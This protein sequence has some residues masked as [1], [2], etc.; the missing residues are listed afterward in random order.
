[1]TVKITRRAAV[2]ALP[3][4][5]LAAKGI[6]YAQAQSKVVKVGVI[7]PMSGPLS[8]YAQE[9][10][11]VI[12]YLFDKINAEG[13]IKSMGG[14]KVELVVADDS[15]QPARAAIEARRLATQENVSVIMGTLLS[16]QMLG[17][18]PIVDEYKVPTLALWAGGA[19]ANH[20]YSLGFPYDRGYAKS[21]ADF[22]HDTGK[23]KTAVVACSDFSAGQKVSAFL[24]EMLKNHGIEVV[25]DVPLDTKATDHTAAMLRIRSMKPDAVIGLMQPRNGI[26][27]MQ[28]R[29][30][31]NYY[32]GA[33]IGNSPY[34]DTVIWR[35]LG[36]QIGKAVL[37]KK[38]F[39]MASF[40]E[41]AKIDSTRTL[42]GELKEKAKL[43]S[44]IGQA[45][46]Q[47]AQGVR[48]I[49]QALE[50][51]GSTDRE[52]IFKA[53]AKVNIPFG[54]KYLYLSRP[55]GLTFG[56]DRMPNDSTAMMVQWT[57]EAKH[58]VVWPDQYAQTKPAL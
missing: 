11:P 33:F 2:A 3:G 28:A 45:A 49:Q 41:G 19:K 30:N 8:S 55:K 18:S 36:A 12:E 25:G 54:D 50:I 1:M 53:I 58:Q 37:P 56:A 51:A 31:A 29:Y 24:H 5:Y 44:Q 27:L 9:G 47:A 16:G 15:S 42:V 43:K 13:G 20:L 39:G 21:M 34:S 57:P 35:E 40:S 10:Q 6:G 23:I 26:M 7:Q 22:A 52:A 32:D 14:A 4:L 38:V 17:V 46:I 48:I